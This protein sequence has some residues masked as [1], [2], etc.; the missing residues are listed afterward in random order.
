M[1]LFSTQA[2]SARLQAATC[3]IGTAS[4]QVSRLAKLTLPTGTRPNAGRR[5]T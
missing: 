1:K 3:I 2:L 4:Y 5:G